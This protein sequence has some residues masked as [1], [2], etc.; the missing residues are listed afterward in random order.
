MDLIL[1]KNGRTLTVPGFWD[2]G[3][4][5]R[6]RFVCPEKG[7]WTFRTVC[8]DRENAALHERRGTAVCADASGLPEIFRRGFVTTRFHKR[9]FTYDDGTPFFY[10]GDTHWSLGEEPADMVRE[11]CKKRVSQGFTVF[12][13]EPICA[14]FDL[15]GG[16]NESQIAG[17]R[18]YDEKFR[19]IADSGL[20]HANAQF[21]FPSGMDAFISSNGG[22]RHAQI[23][24]KIG[25]KPAFAPALSKDAKA[26]LERLSRYWVARYAACPVLWTRG[27]EV[28]DDFY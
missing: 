25:G 2:G 21:F 20:V 3:N 26:A 9:Y 6:F 17:L 19:I 12:Q 14:K 7:V 18:E 16:V 4:G 28:D 11:I 27:Q 5:F 23:P 1:K 24:G 8:S 10:L 15:T 22:Y 13:S